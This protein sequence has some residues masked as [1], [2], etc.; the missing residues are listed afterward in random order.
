MKTTGSEQVFYSASAYVWCKGVSSKLGRH[1]IFVS[2]PVAFTE[3]PG[4]RYTLL[5]CPQATCSFCGEATRYNEKEILFEDEIVLLKSSK[6][7]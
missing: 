7:P 3:D 6:K 1:P 2:S 5:K 4:G